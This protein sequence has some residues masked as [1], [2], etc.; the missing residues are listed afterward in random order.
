MFEWLKDSYSDVRL[1]GLE[2]VSDLGAHGMPSLL[3]S[4]QFVAY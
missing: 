3:Q 4:E 1:T 2:F